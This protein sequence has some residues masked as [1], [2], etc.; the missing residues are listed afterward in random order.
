MNDPVNR[1]ALHV[2][3]TRPAGVG[4]TGG[5]DR[6]MDG[7]ASEVSNRHR[8]RADSQP[9]RGTGHIL[10]AP[11]VLL[12]FTVRLIHLR[13]AGRVQLVHV[14]LASRGSTYRKLIICGV[15]SLLRLPT[16]IHLH[17]G[18]YPRFWKAAPSV[19]RGAIRLMFR[20]C[21][22]VVVLGSVWRD[23]IAGIVPEVAG[24]IVILP[25][26]TSAP[27]RRR[28]SRSDGAL[29]IIFL[30]RVGAGKGVPQLVDALKSLEAVP[31]WR[32][33][34][35]GDGD[36]D[37]TANRVKALGLADR[38]RLTGWVGP[39]AVADLIASADILT[40]PSFD[41]NLPM[42]VIE[43]MAAGLAVVVTPVGAVEDVVTDGVNGLLVPPGDSGALAEALGRLISDEALR[44]RLGAAAVATHRE[45][46]DIGPYVG[47]L[48][49]L[50]QEV[51][52][53]ASQRR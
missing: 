14:N 4:G 15:A 34:I 26:A 46:L 24:R 12:R 35:A 25:N 41:E 6:L 7:I 37:A 27:A 10:L 29:H 17:G 33:T 20:R 21:S 31:N 19:I 52:H 48:V 51:A 3:V 28:T 50:W 30:G 40:L 44:A 1:Q 38:V 2:L 16:V 8:V 32:A 22:R 43:G 42:S 23:F 39:E 53:E 11:F 49:A 18:H 45:K 47:K 5:I 13:C 36:V 9:T